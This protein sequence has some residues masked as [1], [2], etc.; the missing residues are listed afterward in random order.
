MGIVLGALGLL[1]LIV[2]TILLIVTS[3]K[4]KSK[5]AAQ[6]GILVCLLLFVAGTA[7]SSGG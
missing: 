6:I 2:F 4:G 5:Q 1:G 7:L 3:V